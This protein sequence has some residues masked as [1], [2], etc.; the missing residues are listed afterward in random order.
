[1]IKKDTSNRQILV[2]SNKDL[3]TSDGQILVVYNKDLSVRRAIFLSFVLKYETTT[4]KN[5][6]PIELRRKNHNKWESIV[7][8]GENKNAW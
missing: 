3:S 6:Y 5:V 4:K 1:M 7:I 2:I 8:L